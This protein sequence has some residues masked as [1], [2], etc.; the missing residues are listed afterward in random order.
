MLHCQ[1]KKIGALDTQLVWSM[2]Q[3]IP[4]PMDKGSRLGTSEKI[5]R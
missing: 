4:K 2:G 5:Y 1:L 3:K